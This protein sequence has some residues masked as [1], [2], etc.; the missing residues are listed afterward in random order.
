MYQPSLASLTGAQNYPVPAGAPGPVVTAGVGPSF[1]GYGTQPGQE[2]LGWFANLI[3]GLSGQANVPTGTTYNPV[4]PYDTSYDVPLPPGFEG[5]GG[6]GGFFDELLETVKEPL[7]NLFPFVAGQGV[8]FDG[9]ITGDNAAPKSGIMGVIQQAFAPQDPGPGDFGPIYDAVAN[10]VLP[11]TEDFPQPPA[12]P[13]PVEANNFSDV[14]AQIVGVGQQLGLSLQGETGDDPPYTQVEP[15]QSV[16]DASGLGDNPAFNLEGEET[17]TFASLADRQD[18]LY[19][20]DRYG[21]RRGPVPFEDPW[22]ILNDPYKQFSLDTWLIGQA[23]DAYQEEEAELKFQTSDAPGIPQ[24]G[25]GGGFS[26]FF[27]GF[28]GFDPADPSFWLDMVRWLI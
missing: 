24:F 6:G 18:E 16:L 21:T 28:G 1:G 14:I 12:N 25:G 23:L 10:F 27:P 19:M 3:A 8:G 2:D 20:N 13:G 17:G 4:T 22:G 5:S 7:H 11:G 26:P 9:F 15:G